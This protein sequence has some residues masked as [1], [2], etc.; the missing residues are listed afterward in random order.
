MKQLYAIFKI[1]LLAGFFY[2]LII[3]CKTNNSS[4]QKGSNNARVFKESPGDGMGRVLQQEF[5]R[6]ADPNTGDVPSERLKYARF[7]QNERFTQQELFG[8]LNPLSG[9]NWA[10]RGPDNI[11]G[12]TRAILYDLKDPLNKKVWAG[13]VGG[14]IWWTNDITVAD[15]VWNKVN[16]TFSNLAITTIA[17]SPSGDNNLMFFGTGEGWFNDTMYQALGIRGQGIWRSLNGGSSWEHLP[18]TDIP[19]FH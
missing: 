15:P 16:D 17:Q 13:G 4:N 8:K 3:T 18:S 9:L 1:S 2:F 11:G 14:G 5:Q 12:R 7:V 10:E 6:T 19:A